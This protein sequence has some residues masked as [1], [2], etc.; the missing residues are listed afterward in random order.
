MNFRKTLN[1]IEQ[2]VLVNLGVL[3]SCALFFWISLTSLL[4]TLP[5]YL[6][7]IGATSK[8]VGY[9]MGCFAIGLL[10]SRLWLGKLADEGLEKFIF[11][12]PFNLYW[13]KSIVSFLKKIIG[14]LVDY[15]SRK[16]V[17][18]IG[19]SVAFLAPL[20][21]VLFDSF[22]ELMATRA[23][24]GISIA[25]FTTGYSALV[26]DLSP[27]KQKG[28]LIGYMSL[29]VPVGMAIGPALGGF[30]QLNV[31][32]G[33]LFSLSAGSGLIALI[34]ATQIRELDTNYS[35]SNVDSPLKNE[36]LPRQNRTFK[37]LIFNAS[38]FIPFLVLLLIGCL[39]GTLVTFLP[40][41]IRDLGIIFNVGFYYS[42]AAIASFSIRFLS[43]KASDKYG[44]GLFI[45]GSIVCYILSM[46]L[47]AFAR[48]P[49]MLIL[50]AI[51]EGMGAGI[52]IPITLALI[53]DRCSVTERGKVFSLCVTGF[54]VGVALGGPILGSFALDWGYQTIFLITATMATLALFIF[55][56]FGNKNLSASWG[57]A[58]GY[59]TDLYALKD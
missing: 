24:H 32:Y 16:I 41:Y 26:V 30:L 57:F 27:P 22:P 5:I 17:I 25:A 2:K 21:Y 13:K 53:S 39:F 11:S 42:T 1:N 51:L 37:Q 38:F 14:G 34:L 58:V 33:F 35:P 6:Q 40:L 18:I 54:D 36:G 12:L 46:I 20:G 7:D 19:A 56:S 29:A 8:Q 49:N 28:E 23:F 50:S 44:R 9:I 59:T 48:S 52:F 55:G 10:F 43:G 31:S 4:P 3:F 47:L 45:S 15:P